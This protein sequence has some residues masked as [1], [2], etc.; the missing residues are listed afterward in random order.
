MAT[1][2]NGAKQSAPLIHEADSAAR[3][4]RAS[5]HRRAR[6]ASQGSQTGPACQKRARSARAP[7]TKNVRDGDVPGA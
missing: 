4:L 5:S 7:I 1:E 6:M 3:K 2:R